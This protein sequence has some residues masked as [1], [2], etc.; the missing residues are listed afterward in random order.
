MV[1]VI[2][3]QR[4]VATYILQPVDWLS[5]SARSNKQER[6]THAFLYKG[7]IFNHMAHSRSFPMRHFTTNNL[8]SCASCALGQFLF[9]RRV[10]TVTRQARDFGLRGNYA[11]TSGC[12]PICFRLTYNQYPTLR[13]RG[14]TDSNGRLADRRLS[15]TR[16]HTSFPRGYSVKAICSLTPEFF[17]YQLYPCLSQRHSP[18]ST[19]TDNFPP[20]THA[21]RNGQAFLHKAVQSSPFTTASVSNWVCYPLRFV[22]PYV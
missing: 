21:S 15:I 5:R 11:I 13:Y 22:A 7:S 6:K 16:A 9:Y 2:A 14:F 20:S 17:R 8:T 12:H 1:F 18:S 19:I 4:E 3:P 10:R